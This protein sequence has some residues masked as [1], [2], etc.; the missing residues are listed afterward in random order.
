MINTVKILSKKKIK[1]KSMSGKEIIT[2]D[3][4]EKKYKQIKI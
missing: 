3:Q 1:E 2:T 4:G